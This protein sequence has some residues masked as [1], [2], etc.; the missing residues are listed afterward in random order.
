MADYWGLSAIAQ[1]LGCKSGQTAMRFHLTEGLPM[2]KR[3]DPTRAYSPSVW[4]SNDRLLLAW[5]L[6]LA[7][8]SRKR[9][10]AAGKGRR[11]RT[12]TP[13]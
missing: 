12:E 7:A 8:R 5:Q 13:A 2:F 6:T 1:A 3:S 11:V 9:L 10:L 4:Y